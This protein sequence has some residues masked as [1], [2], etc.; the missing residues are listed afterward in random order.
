MDI[1]SKSKRSQV[2]ARIRSKN[3]KPEKLIRSLLHRLGLRFRL[4]RK[5]LPGCPD[6]VMP[7]W[8]AVIFVNGCFWHLHKNCRDGKFPRTDRQAWKKKLLKNVRRDR[9]A[10][11]AL[12]RAGWNTIV[13]WECEL[14]Q[15]PTST[16]ERIAELVRGRGLKQPRLGNGRARAG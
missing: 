5:S 3:T 11:R 14:R 10:I 16:A 13:V 6:I 9:N 1:W 2:M 7:K 4:H 15:N 8:N 12:I